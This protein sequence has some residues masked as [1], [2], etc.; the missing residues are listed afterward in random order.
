MKWTAGPITLLSAFVMLSAIQNV[1]STNTKETCMGR[2]LGLLPDTTLSRSQV[3]LLLKS[4]PPPVDQRNAQQA[5][6]VALSV[7]LG[8]D[9]ARKL[10][11]CLTGQL[12]ACQRN[13]PCSNAGQC[14]F[15]RSG[16]HSGSYGCQCDIGYTGD[17]C[18]T[19]PRDTPGNCNQSAMAIQLKQDMQKLK[20]EA[21]AERKANMD[22]IGDFLARLEKKIDV[23]S[24]EISRLHGNEQQT[25]ESTTVSPAL[26]TDTTA[27]AQ[28]CSRTD[29]GPSG[30]FTFR[31]NRGEST[32]YCDRE[33]DGGGWIVF[34]RRQDGSVDFDRNW[35]SYK[36]GFGNPTEEFWLGLE[37]IHY[38]T[39]Q[40]STRYE[41]RLDLVF[42][43]SEEMHSATCSSFKVDSE[44]TNYTLHVSGFFSTTLPDKVTQHNGDTF[45]TE[46]HGRE[47][48][49]CATYWSGG[50]WFSGCYYFFLN[51]EYGQAISSN[52]Y[53]PRFLKWVLYS[54]MKFRLI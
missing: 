47:Q 44:A 34:Q 6:Q 8:R 31:T 17:Y 10:I 51:G 32:A 38:L 20:R 28:G 27:S 48:N 1:I 25:D 35:Q 18:E 40:P 24:N 7:L 54:E 5:N 3:E 41:L 37:D 49:S 26:S 36:N 39:S 19:G 50:W 43:T 21:E 11:Q 14:I 46:D 13:H 52:Y 4:I 12:Q 15:S 45:S 33:T 53:H 42:N 23:V 29:Q 2:V 16:Q 9:T 22:H 30:V